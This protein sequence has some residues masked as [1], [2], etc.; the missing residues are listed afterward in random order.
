M[1]RHVLRALIAIGLMQAAQLEYRESVEEWRRQ[2][3]ARLK[4][5]DGWL[6]VAGLFWLKTGA[7]RFGP[8]EKHPISLPADVKASGAFHLLDGKVTAT[9][10][11][12]PVRSKALRPD[13][14]TDAIQLGRISMFVIQRGDRFAIRMRDQQSQA[15]REFR[16]LEWYLVKPE[17]RVTAKFVPYNP[18]KSIPVPN[19]IGGTFPE[20]CPGYAE[21]ALRGEKL[22]LEPVL[23]DG[24]LF[25]I[26]RDQTSGRKTYGAGR[27][28]YS[29]MAKDGTVT[30]DFNLAYT[31]PCAFT[32]YATCPLPPKQNR[33]PVAIEAGELDYGH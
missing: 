25:Y 4:A 6:T 23:S 14:E 27:F 3:E 20:T 2:R 21:F 31:P 26:F 16:G 18:P 24:R 15:R 32:P 8:G 22:R 1:A 7:N 19:I 17:Y 33:L 5:D 29:D 10:D 12:T 9:V 13:Q 11:G 30:L 28:L